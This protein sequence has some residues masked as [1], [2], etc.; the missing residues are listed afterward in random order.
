M[1]YV[2]QRS[3]FGVYFRAKPSPKLK[4][5]LPQRSRIMGY[6]VMTERGVDTALAL[7][8]F[9]IL[10]FL[11]RYP[12]RLNRN[13]RVH[14]VVYAVFFLSSTVALL[15][16]TL[17]GMRVAAS[18]NTAL[19][20]FSACS[21]LAWLIF[22]TPAGEKIQDKQSRM[23]PEQEKRLLGQLDVLNATLLRVSRQQMR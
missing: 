20:I 22:L 17:L 9:L 3:G 6:L 11:S 15:L 23:E 19:I 7:F 18:V 12:V 13:T 8:I 2:R 16:R 10:L 14:A 21:V 4:P 1:G 5:S